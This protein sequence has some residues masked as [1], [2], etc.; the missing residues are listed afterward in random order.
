MIRAI[1]TLFS[2]QTLG[3]ALDLLIHRQ[4]LAQS[5]IF[6]TCEHM[7]IFHTLLCKRMFGHLLFW[8]KLDNPQILFLKYIGQ[9]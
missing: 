6:R 2:A 9:T 3:P 4:Y 5:A 1:I 7:P 8:Y